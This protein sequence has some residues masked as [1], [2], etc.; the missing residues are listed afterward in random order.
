MQ[1][2]PEVTVRMRGVMEKCTF[3]VQRIQSARIK[4]KN[5]WAKQGGT[6]TGTPDFV[7]PDGTIT[8]ACQDA[9]PA[10]AIVF[11]DLNDPNSRV[12]KLHGD[13]RSYQMLEELNT[14]TRLKYMARITNPVASP[15]HGDSHGHDDH[16]DEHGRR[17]QHDGEAHGRAGGA[18]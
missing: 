17:D 9:C 8:T 4:A 11:G 6:K 1:F 3:C 12:K 14:K 15:G 2:N 18:A 16:H 5:A 13:D 7:I 10:E